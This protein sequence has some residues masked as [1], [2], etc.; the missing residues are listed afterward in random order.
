M[1]NQRGNIKKKN[2]P[3]HIPISIAHYTPKTP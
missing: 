1:G 2:G 3:S